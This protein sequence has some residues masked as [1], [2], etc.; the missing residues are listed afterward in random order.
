MVDAVIAPTSFRGVQ[1]FFLEPHIRDI[2]SRV[3]DRASLPVRPTKLG[4]KAF[5]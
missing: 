5:T 4:P 1:R 3:L 2:S